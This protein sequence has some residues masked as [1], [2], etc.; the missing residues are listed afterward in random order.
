MMLHAHALAFDHPATGRRVE[1]VARLPE[2]FEAHA[3]LM[4]R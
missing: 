2:E 1:V 3:R 4:D